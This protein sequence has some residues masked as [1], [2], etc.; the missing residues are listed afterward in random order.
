MQHRTKVESSAMPRPLCY[1][2]FVLCLFAACASPSSSKSSA[3]SPAAGEVLRISLRDY[4]KGSY[5]ALVSGDEET[6]VDYYSEQRDEAATKVQT[7]EVMNALFQVFE[8]RGLAALSQVGQ[9]PAL[10]AGATK[11]LELRRGEVVKHLVRR[12]GMKDADARAFEEYVMAFI[13]VYQQTYAL[14]SVEGDE[15]SFRFEPAKSSKN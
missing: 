4:R 13:E 8:D 14:Q 2:S 10:E 3:T 6:R 7:Y 5:F 11:A 12:P 1:L 15:Q 9:A